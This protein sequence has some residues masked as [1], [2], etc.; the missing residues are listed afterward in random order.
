M[1]MFD[2][3]KLLDCETYE[4]YLDS[5][6]QPQDMFYLRDPHFARMIV[7]LGY[8]FVHVELLISQICS[9]IIRRT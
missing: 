9:A 4:E 1:D 5:F 8:R 3:R 2:E 6:V 7:Q